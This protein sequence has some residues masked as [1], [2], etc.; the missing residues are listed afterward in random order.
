M[1]SI[2]NF[3][4]KL[5][6]KVVIDK[7]K[8]INLPVKVTRKS[9]EKLSGMAK[10]PQGVKYEKIDIDG[11][12]VE[13]CIPDNLKNAGV[14]LYTHGGGYVAGSIRTHRGTTG[15][16][17]IASKTKCI[18]VE[19][20][21]APENPFP[22]ALNDV[23]KVYHFLLKQGYDS[24]KIVISGDSAGGGLAVAT[25]LKLRDDNA[26]QPA[27]GVLLSPWLDL[28]LTGQSA[29]TMASTDPMVVPEAL[30]EFGLMYTTKDNLRNPLTSPLYA[31]LKGLPPFYI[32]ASSSEV[33][34]D[35]TTRFEKKLKEAGVVCNVEYWKNMLH[36]WQAYAPVL[37]EAQKA[38]NKLGEYIEKKTR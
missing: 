6:L 27:A 11:V 23:I 33:L 25:L 19:Y 2:Q 24:K 28:E 8:Q 34:Y 10:L 4:I 21:L 13:W 26:P 31:N 20:G 7:K 3:F 38:I 35:D 17:A 15:R 37:P 18:S 5:F 9:L 1:A 16:L 12:P 22:A 32:Q 30:R 29:T 14:I 36:V